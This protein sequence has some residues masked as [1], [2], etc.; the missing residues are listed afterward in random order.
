MLKYW[1]SFFSGAL[2][3]IIFLAALVLSLLV[4][5]NPIRA[6]QTGL[7]SSVDVVATAQALQAQRRQTEL[8]L[9]A[10]AQTELWE[11]QLAGKRA[12][13]TQANQAGQTRVVQLQTQLKNAKNQLSQA[14]ESIRVA[15]TQITALEQ[16]IANDRQAYQAELA[17]LER[18][19][20]QSEQAFK[21]QFEAV[22]TALQSAQAEL[23]ARSPA[24]PSGN[25][26]HPD[27]S[28]DNDS[29]TDDHETDNKT[30]DDDGN[31]D[32]H[33]EDGKEDDRDDD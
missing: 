3:L 26:S 24:A 17:Q 29:F 11:S 4:L 23:A 12:T 33:R 31:E 1:Q 5:I 25:D 16:A 30:G 6:G 19:K 20:H 7:R 15:Q 22:Q 14:D 10:R 9:A 18:D 2:L 8:D 28:A 27:S 13:L 32:D 21:A